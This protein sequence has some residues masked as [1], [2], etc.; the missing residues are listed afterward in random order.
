M[1]MNDEFA[2]A[3][4]ALDNIDFSKPNADKVPVFEVVIRYLGGLLGAWDISEHRHPILLQKARELGEFLYK[5]FDTENGLPVPNYYWKQ[6][7]S[8]KLPG[9]DKVIIAQIASLSLEFIRLSQVTGD[10][11]YAAAIQIV[12]ATGA[13]AKPYCITW[14]VAHSSKLQW[15][16]TVVPR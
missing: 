7:T 1:G 15:D 11:K 4:A 8:G 6:A 16:T 3:V 14:N 10:P 5:I 13:H 9:E 12:T 2:E